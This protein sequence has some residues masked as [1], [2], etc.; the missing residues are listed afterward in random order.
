MDKP[1]L[2]VDVGIF[3]SVSA[4][5]LA[6]AT[7]VITS[8]VTGRNTAKK[9]HQLENDLLNA[10]LEAVAAKGKSEAFEEGLARLEK[11]QDIMHLEQKQFQQEQRQSAAELQKQISRILERIPQLGR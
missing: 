4:V 1:E 11:Q 10:R 6:V 3:V 7:P 9:L 5:V 2:G 8:I